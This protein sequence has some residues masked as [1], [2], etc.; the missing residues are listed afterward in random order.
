VCSCGDIVLT[1][2]SPLGS[3]A[4]PSSFLKEAGAAPLV[5]LH[6]MSDSVQRKPHLQMN[7][8]IEIQT[9]VLS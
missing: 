4:D 2:L 7:A 3:S 6:M 1:R 9:C 8:V 5:M